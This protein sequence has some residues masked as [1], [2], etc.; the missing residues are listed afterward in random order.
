M[1]VIKRAF[2]GFTCHAFVE[3]VARLRK[4]YACKIKYVQRGCRKGTATGNSSVL[5][6]GF[7]PAGFGLP[8]LQPKVSSLGSLALGPRP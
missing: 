5:L 1:C 2:S 7:L 3:R 8:A 6:G 4:Q